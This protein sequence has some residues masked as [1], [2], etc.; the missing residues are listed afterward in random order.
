MDES[1]L[2]FAAPPFAD[3]ACDA[4]RLPQRLRIERK[5]TWADSKCARVS[6]GGADS[7]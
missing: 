2:V 4:N 6:A 3:V 1:H 5:S 7:V